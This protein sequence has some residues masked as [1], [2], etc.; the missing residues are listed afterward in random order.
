MTA[1]RGLTYRGAE[2]GLL[3]GHGGVD[4]FVNL[5]RLSFGSPEIVDINDGNCTITKNN[6]ILQEG[7]SGT[8]DTLSLMYG[9]TDGDIIMVRCATSIT[10]EYIS[11][12]RGMR[13]QE[14]N[15]YLVTSPDDPIWFIKDV[16]G[17]WLELGRSVNG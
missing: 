13:L 15:D 2:G 4:N 14:Q 6:I 7:S 12:N 10:L 3:S 5:R 16:G 1:Y 9:G 8:T 17:R 11:T